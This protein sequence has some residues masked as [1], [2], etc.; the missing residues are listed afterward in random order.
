MEYARWG[1]RST[2]LFVTL[3]HNA[4]DGVP[5]LNRLRNTLLFGRPVVARAFH[6]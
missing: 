4:E 3:T 5:N 1:H 6:N 2:R